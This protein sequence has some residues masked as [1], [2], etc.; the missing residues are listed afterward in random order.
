MTTQQQLKAELAQALMEI[1]RLQHAVREAAAAIQEIKVSVHEGYRVRRH[2]R[3]IVLEVLSKAESPAPALA[4]MER[5]TQ[6]PARGV[7]ETWY[8]EGEFYLNTDELENYLS[9]NNE[10]TPLL[11]DGVWYWKP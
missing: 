2:A 8:Y 4:G 11:I 9:L 5:L 7:G 3:L 6:Q 1:E 10:Y